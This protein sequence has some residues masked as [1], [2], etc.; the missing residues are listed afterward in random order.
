MSCPHRFVRGRINMEEM[1][2]TII[3]EGCGKEA[4]PEMPLDKSDSLGQRVAELEKGC[5][6]EVT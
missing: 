5:Q 1:T 4:Q 2:Y 6:P 3:C